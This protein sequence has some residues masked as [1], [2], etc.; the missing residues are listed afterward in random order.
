[1]DASSHLRG[2]KP[3]R[4]RPARGPR[5]PKKD[6]NERTRLDSPGQMGAPF[7][8]GKRGVDLWSRVGTDPALAASIPAAS[9]F[10]RRSYGWLAAS[11]IRAARMSHAGAEG[12]SR[13]PTA[14]LRVSGLRWA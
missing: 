1:M 12:R 11:S 4:F 8:E 2:R 9:P 7:S 3:H 6:Q 13:T 14:S 5:G 10:L